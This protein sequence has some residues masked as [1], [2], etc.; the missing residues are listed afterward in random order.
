MPTITT[1]SFTVTSANITTVEVGTNCPQGGDSGH[2]GRT[3][4]RIQD[5]AATDLRVRCDDGPET[6]ANSIAIILG[7]DCECE[8]FIELLERGL[9]ALKAQHAANQATKNTREVA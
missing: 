6:D 7:G 2:G 5:E 3:L 9:A 4:F 1:T 8:A